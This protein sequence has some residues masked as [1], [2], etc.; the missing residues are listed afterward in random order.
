LNKLASYITEI[1]ASLELPDS[2]FIS[3]A[4]L[5]PKVVGA[6]ELGKFRPIACLTTIR[7]LLGYTWLDMLPPLHFETFQTGFVPGS[8]ATAGVFALQRVF[9]LS[10]EWGC[11]AYVA[12]LDLKK[13]FDRVKHSAAL[14]ALELQGA[15]LQCRAIF[16]EMMSK[17]SLTFSLGN[18][19]S[20]AIGLERGLPQGAPESPLVFILIVEMVIRPLQRSWIDR[21]WGWRLDTFWLAFIGYADD[22]LLVSDSKEI[23][24]T[25]IQETIDAFETVG[26][27]VGTD[28]G[29]SHWTCFPPA[30]NAKL[31]VGP[32]EVQWECSLTF[33]G[34]VID[35]RSKS[36][37]ATNYRLAQAGKSFAV[38]RPILLLRKIAPRRRL[39]LAAKAVFTS[40]TWLAA[41]WHMTVAIEQKLKS[42]TAR[43]AARIYGVRP[44]PAE[45][46]GDFW[47]RWHRDGHAILRNAGGGVAIIWRRLLHRFAG[48]AARKTDGPV[49][50]ALRCRC[51][52]WWRF[53]QDV[54]GRFALRGRFGR[55]IRWES[56]LENHYGKAMMDSENQNAGWLLTAQ[57]RD[58]WRAGEASFTAG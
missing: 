51:L 15:T 16:S 52:P 40:L 43:I 48:H 49:H 44:R 28:Q 17:S 13:A 19:C 41:T 38:W 11:P 29:K 22:I 33:I 42:W 5:L 32:H 1:M 14:R 37:A 27:E 24:E 4:I 30:E 9:E 50:D 57:D 56:P 45:S 2:W 26:L 8:E 10:R 55:P 20:H 7:K 53:R 34:T 46:V 25:M 21:G 18:E 47:R 31:K 35:C 6:A 54:T 23:L 39:G 58:A 36:T 12:Q 3:R